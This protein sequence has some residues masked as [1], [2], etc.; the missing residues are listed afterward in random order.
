MKTKVTILFLLL[1]SVLFSQF[2]KDEDLLITII[3]DPTFEDRGVQYGVQL[4]KELLWGWTGLE[5]TRY[6]QLNP[7][8]QDLVASGGI[9]VHPWVERITIY[10][11]PRLGVLWRGKNKYPLAGVGIGIDVD[12]TKDIRIGGRLWIDHREDQKDEFFGDS[13]GYERG[14]ITNNPLLQENGAFTITW[15][16]Q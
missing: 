4:R 11:G 7:V 5:L 14:I 15:V 8:Y 2:N 3:A 9:C 16:V 6:E 12:L 10:A 13:S 1:S